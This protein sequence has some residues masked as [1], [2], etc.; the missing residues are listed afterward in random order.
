[1]QDERG[2]FRAD[3]LFP[4]LLGFFSGLMTPLA[5]GTWLDSE[6]AILAGLAVSWSI[7]AYVAC[8]IAPRGFD[9]AWPGIV[10][11]T[12]P[13]SLLMVVST[14]WPET[15]SGV[16]RMF[17][18]LLASGVVGLVAGVAVATRQPRRLK[19]MVEKPWVPH[20]A[21]SGGRR[22]VG[23]CLFTLW[24]GAWAV[25]HV[26]QSSEDVVFHQFMAVVIGTVA[27]FAGYRTWEEAK[28]WWGKRR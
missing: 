23:W 27:L 2:T 22:V 8:R 10:A 20:R 4:V 6:A 7:Y 19:A 11:L 1:M 25:D 18:M 5:L 14:Q 24:S 28:G 15:P 16:R 9:S 21:P 12:V 13:L 26:L 17:A 3:T